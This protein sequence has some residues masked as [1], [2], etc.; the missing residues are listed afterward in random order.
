MAL[1][2]E[3]EGDNLAIVRIT[4]VL[5]RIEADAIKKQIV[6]FIKCHGRA[7]VL[8]IIDDRFT[9]IAKFVN[10]D[11]D[12]DD[13]FLQKHVDRLALVGDLKWRDSALLFLLHGFVPFGIE[14]FK[15]GQEEFAKAWLDS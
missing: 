12:E 6:A 2:V 7:K 3:F 11:D 1:A 10:W 14:Y 13:E 5:L 15:P 9:E 8:V 4:G